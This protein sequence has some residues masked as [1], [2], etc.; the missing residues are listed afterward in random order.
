MISVIIPIHNSALTLERCLDSLLQQ[1]YDNFEIICIENGSTDNSWEIISRYKILNTRVEGHNL[2]GVKSVSQARNKGLQLATGD[3]VMFVDQDDWVGPEY[4]AIMANALK[5]THA[6]LVVSRWTEVPVIR[7]CGFK[8]EIITWKSPNY[9]RTALTPMVWG[10]L[11]K[12]E[13]LKGLSFDEIKIGEDA[14]FMLK[15]S[16]KKPT[17]AFI[18]SSEYFYSINPD[19]CTSN[20]TTKAEYLQYLFIYPKIGLNY[21]DKA[22]VSQECRSAWSNR[23]FQTI[24]YWAK[25]IQSQEIWSLWEQE[26]LEF[27]KTFPLPSYFKVISKLGCRDIANKKIILHEFAISGF[28]QRQLRRIKIWI[29]MQ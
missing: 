8:S 22:D 23:S 3:Q 24:F 5:E 19:S 26:L 13:Y 12:A 25:K 4:L 14:L 9:W 20:I 15:F 2:V 7:L 27:G 18:D 6:D 16:L 17:I 10:K 28:I 11:F 21:L 1:T 29:R